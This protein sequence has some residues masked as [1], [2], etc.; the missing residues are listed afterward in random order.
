MNYR[1]TVIMGSI[2]SVNRCPLSDYKRFKKFGIKF[3]YCTEIPKIKKIPRER[4][5]GGL[6]TNKKS[7]GIRLIK[8]RTKIFHNFNFD[9]IMS[10]VYLG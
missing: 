1:A 3:T 10:H 2:S 7:L 5:K 9:V 8:N 4:E 6:W